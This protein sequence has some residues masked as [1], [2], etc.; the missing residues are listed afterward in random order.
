[1]EQHKQNQNQRKQQEIKIH[2]NTQNTSGDKIAHTKKKHNK[3]QISPKWSPCKTK[4]D[5]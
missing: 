2:K 4:T 3:K 1:M 5:R